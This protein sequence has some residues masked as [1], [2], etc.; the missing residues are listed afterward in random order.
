MRKWNPYNVTVSN[1][2]VE[3]FAKK[4]RIS[5]WYSKLCLHIGLFITNVIYLFQGEGKS[6][7]IYSDQEINKQISDKISE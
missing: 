5:L 1:E 4:K 2:W 6:D 3:E 7:K